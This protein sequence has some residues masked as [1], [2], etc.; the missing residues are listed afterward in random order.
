MPPSKS[1]LFRLFVEG[2]DDLHAISHLLERHGYDWNHNASAPWI[3][4][5][6]GVEQLLRLLP[7][8]LKT[9]VRV[10]VVIDADLKLPNRWAQVAAILHER[11]ITPP[12]SLDRQGLVMPVAGPSRLERLGLWLMPDNQSPGML[13]DFLRR[14]VPPNDRCWAHADEATRQ[15]RILGGSLKE[16]DHSKG[17][18]HTWLAW[19]DPPG[20]T[21]GT[22]LN[23]GIF[24]CEHR[25]ALGFVAWF[26]RLFDA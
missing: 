3:H 12:S 18:I 7:S 17:A 19:Q 20:R 14:L 26:R 4:D 9:C 25:E 6:G 13:E 15:A 1:S 2:K 23:A 11:G 5:S 8:A 21:F 16:A 10:G 22:A 24:D